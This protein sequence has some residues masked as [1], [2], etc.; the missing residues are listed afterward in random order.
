MLPDESK[1]NGDVTSDQWA[2]F[3]SFNS[4]SSFC[5]ASGISFND[6]VF[7]KVSMAFNVSPFTNSVCQ[8][9][10]QGFPFIILIC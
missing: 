9:H 4:V 6:K 10:K 7:L 2:C 8:C 5:F 3:L 1:K